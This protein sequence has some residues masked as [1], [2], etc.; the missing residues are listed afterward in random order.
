[1]A[2]ESP[3]VNPERTPFIAKVTW[4]VFLPLVGLVFLFHRLVQFG[5]KE[6]TAIQ[7]AAV[8]AE[9]CVWL[10]MGYVICRAIES[11]CRS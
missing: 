3:A 8:A 4:A 11:L 5:S 6:I 9:T 7:Q 2:H 10:I 1:M